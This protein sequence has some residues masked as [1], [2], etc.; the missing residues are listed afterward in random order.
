MK[1]LCYESRGLKLEHSNTQPQI[2]HAENPR[3]RVRGVAK[4]IRMNSEVD[5]SLGTRTKALPSGVDGQSSNPYTS[6]CQNTKNFSK[7]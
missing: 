7:D 4:L 3:I 2:L 5:V 1:F 6:S